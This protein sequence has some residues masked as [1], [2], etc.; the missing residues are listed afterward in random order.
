MKEKYPK[1][2]SY[3]ETKGEY[4]KT[5]EKGK[6]KNSNKCYEFSRNQNFECQKMRKLLVPGLA[7]EARYC[8][9]EENVFIDQGS[10]GIILSDEYKD[11]EY[12]VL[13]LLNSKLLGFIVPQ[14][15][16]WLFY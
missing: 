7:Q 2:F 9:G 3:L 11:K 6:W 1:T 15:K 8:V 13:G 5:R 12:F 4:L 10:Y 14:P 16:L